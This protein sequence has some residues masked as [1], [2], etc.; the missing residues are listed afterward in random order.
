[1]SQLLIVPYLRQKLIITMTCLLWTAIYAKKCMLNFLNT[2]FYIHNKIQT[3]DL[4]FIST[5]YVIRINCWHS[6]M[7][8]LNYVIHI[9]RADTKPN[10]KTD[11]NIVSLKVTKCNKAAVQRQSSPLVLNLRPWLTCA[12]PTCCFAVAWNF[13]WILQNETLSAPLSCSHCMYMSLCVCVCA[14]MHNVSAGEQAHAL[15]S[16]GCA[17]SV[18][19]AS[20]LLSFGKTSEC[21]VFFT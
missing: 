2:Y 8:R 21:S 1:M 13:V 19:S 6:S 15:T 10:W 14:C 7:E 18:L 5:C 4:V 12:V 16:M 20:E 17:S 9:C 11:M 3:L